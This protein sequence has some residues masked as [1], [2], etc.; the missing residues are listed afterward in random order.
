MKDRR[1]IISFSPEIRDNSARDAR[2]AI[3]ALSFAVTG[4]TACGFHCSVHC[5]VSVESR[6]IDKEREGGRKTERAK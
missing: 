1:A 3:G 2:H 4:N 6:R 5:L